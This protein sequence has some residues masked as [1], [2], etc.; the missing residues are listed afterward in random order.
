MATRRLITDENLKRFGIN[1]KN[2]ISSTQDSLNKKIAAVGDIASN[3]T[4]KA[5]AAAEKANAA[6]DKANTAAAS[7]E[8]VNATLKDSTISV[9]NRKGET[10]TI[11]LMTYTDE[12]VTVTITSSVSDITV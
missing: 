7:A 5:D 1:V 11:A 2:T 12:E 4:T 6:A 8:N 10:K 3:A 9:T